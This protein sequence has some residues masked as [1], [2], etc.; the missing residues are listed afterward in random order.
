MKNAFSKEII[1][2]DEVPLKDYDQNN[3]DKIE[4]LENLKQSESKMFK[5]KPVKS[6]LK[7]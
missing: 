6:H 4:I 1:E 3:K 5:N 2:D 7:R